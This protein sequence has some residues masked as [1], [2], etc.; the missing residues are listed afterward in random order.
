MTREEFKAWL[1][2]NY[3][4]GSRESSMGPELVENILAWAG[5]MSDEDMYD[6]LCF[7]F[8]DVPESVIRRVTY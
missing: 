5:R 1:H 8:D 6:F 3:H 2:E 4:V 7:M